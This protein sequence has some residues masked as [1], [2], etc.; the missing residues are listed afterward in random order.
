MQILKNFLKN[1]GVMILLIF[2]GMTMFFLFESFIEWEWAT[3]PNPF[4]WDSKLTRL[5]IAVL[6]IA[7]FLQSF[8]IEHDGED[9]GPL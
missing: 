2:I 7:A 1:I 5:L 3:Y 4:T 6:I 9:M 8:D